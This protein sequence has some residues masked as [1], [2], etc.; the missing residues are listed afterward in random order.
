MILKGKSR[1]G[2]EVLGRYLANAETNERVELAEVKGTVA[3]DLVGALIEMDA[4]A[5]GTQCQKP[6]YHGII[7]PQPPH[8]LTPAQRTE[9]VHAYE[10]EMG[11][12]GH[13]RVV[14]VH[15][16]EGREHIH[17]VWTRIDLENMRAVPVNHDYRKHE[18]VARA[19]ERRFGHDRVQG[20]HAERDGQQRPDYSPSRA[21]LAQERRTGIKGKE[22]K[23]EVTALFRASD[24][25]EGFCAALNDA[26][27]ILARGDRRDFMIV[28]RAGGYHSLGRRIEGMK[29]DEL[30]EFMAPIDRK[31]LPHLSEAQAMAEDRLHGIVPDRD[32]ERWEDALAQSAIKKFDK[33]EAERERRRAFARE[34]HVKALREARWER[35][36]DYANQSRQALH[37]HE[38]IRKLLDTGLPRPQRPQIYERDEERKA[39]DEAREV[40]HRRT[41]QQRSETP[42]APR[43]PSPFDDL[44]MNDAIAA[45]MRR[46][47]DSGSREERER[48]R[49][50][51]EAYDRQREAP[52]GGRS[53]SR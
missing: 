15:E 34:A 22:V 46:M 40:Q 16:K 53:R 21:E 13:A 25:V 39:L 52:G 51:G 33:D 42:A 3:Q 31:S 14:V 26:G 20:A 37:D 43:A 35:S 27:Y 32:K 28:D 23:A 17:V 19:L 45:R 48:E 36:D 18:N 44:E 11:F 29:A 6:L 50:D 5:E 4:Y 38:R 10:K 7:S 12:T 8:R 1:T 49:D 47:L 41:E 30:R 2:A 9:A 24:S